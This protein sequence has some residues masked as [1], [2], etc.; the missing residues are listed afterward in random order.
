MKILHVLRGL[1]GTS[2]ISAFLVQN[3]DRQAADGHQVAVLYERHFEYRPSES[4]EVFRRKMPFGIAFAPDIV[5]IHA[6]WSFFSVFA[7][8]WCALRRI[9]FIVS[10]HGCLMP[11]VFERGAWRKKTFY[12]LFVRPMMRK[13]A[14]IHVTAAQEADVIRRL[15]F[16]QD[17]EIIPL[18]VDVSAG[19]KPCRHKPLRTMLFMGR[20]SAEKGL[21]NLLRAWRQ[22]DGAGWRLELAGP[23]WKGHK[24]VLDEEIRQLG[25]SDNVIFTGSVVGE[26]KEEAYCNADCFVLPSPMENFSAVVLEALAHSL[27]VIATKGTPWRELEEFGCGWWV[28]IEVSALREALEKA[29]ALPAEKRREMGERGRRLVEGKYTW[30]AVV[31]ALERAYESVLR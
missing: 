15:G 27:P 16:A 1:E 17:V 18:G 10:P 19:G 9:P 12:H 6:I 25:L 11:S 4:V 22:I 13:A 8:L 30:S 20:L 14:A 3:A 23:D 7:M 31:K 28:D 2:G 29:T 5:H 21:V 24:A 26:A